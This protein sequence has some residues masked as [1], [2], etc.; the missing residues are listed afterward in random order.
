VVARPIAPRGHRG[1]DGIQTTH[2]LGLR[3]ALTAISVV[4][5]V[6]VVLAPLLATG[7]LREDEQFM[8]VVGPAA[9]VFPLLDVAR[10]LPWALAVLAGSVLVA[11]EHGDIGSVGIALCAGAVL[12][13]GESVSAAGALAPLAR[14]ELR[15][16]R[17]LVL[18]IAAEAAG[19]AVLAAAVL[20]ASSLGIPAGLAPLALGLLATVSLLALVAGLVSRR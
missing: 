3:I 18:R 1:G 14:I 13:V 7:S 19:A 17:R 11:S 8:A 9:L 16:A 4:A 5:A 6:A 15:L 12:L 20:A 10:L 2:A